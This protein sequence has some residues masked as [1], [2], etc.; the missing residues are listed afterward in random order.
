LV[1]ASKHTHLTALNEQFDGEFA[2]EMLSTMRGIIKKDSRLK[3]GQRVELETYNDYPDTVKNAA[4]RGIALNEKVNNKCATDVGKIR[5]QQL[6]NGRNISVQTIK[7]MYAYTSRARE[8]YKPEDTSACGTISYLL[9]GGDA[10]NS[11]SAAKLKK[12]GLFQGETAV[13]VSSS[14]AGQFGKKKKYKAPAQL[15]LEEGVPH[16]TADGKLYEGP[17]H[18]DAE[19]RLMTGEVHSEDSEYLYHKEELEAQPSIPN[20]SYPGEEAKGKKKYKSPALLS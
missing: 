5:A 7:L 13:S 19:G 12:L 11:W 2:D 18:K 16:Y 4:K 20:S 10:A 1:E 14:Y 15:S 6:A 3:D 17:T 8:F 9:W